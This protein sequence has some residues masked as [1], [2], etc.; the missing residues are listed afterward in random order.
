MVGG[1]G[2]GPSF[3]NRSSPMQGLM[4]LSASQPGHGEQYGSPF[5]HMG[6][7]AGLDGLDGGTEFTPLDDEIA[8]A[9]YNHPSEDAATFSMNMN[10]LQQQARMMPVGRNKMSP[11]KDTDQGGMLRGIG[12]G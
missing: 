9:G 10:S 7:T 12:H 4:N 2:Q 6:S 11:S 5:G 3:G 1:S 8:D